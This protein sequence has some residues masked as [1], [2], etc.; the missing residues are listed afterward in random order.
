MTASFRNP[1]ALLIPSGPR[2]TEQQIWMITF[3]DLVGLLLAFFVMIFAMSS[4]DQTRFSESHGGEDLHREPLPG[5][6][7]ATVQAE[8][9]APQ[10]TVELGHDLGYLGTLL[11]E[12][13]SREK[14]LAGTIIRQDGSQIILSLPAQLLFAP[15]GAEP[16][17]QGGQALFALVGLLRN[18]QNRIE[19]EGHADPKPPTAPAFVSN[20]EL[21]LARATAVALSLEAAGYGQNVLIRG[22]AAARYTE[23]AESLAPAERDALARR[24]DIIVHEEAN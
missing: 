24:V 10:A 15:N 8:R 3:T 1:L 20:W 9:N 6:A 22:R 11:R 7:E 23:I 21:S 4:I 19:V 17:A 2:T 13:I 14:L 16:T 12:Q 18:L 5:A